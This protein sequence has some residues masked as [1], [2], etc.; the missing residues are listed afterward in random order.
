[1]RALLFLLLSACEVMPPSAC[2]PCDAV[3]NPCPDRG[4]V[5]NP[6]RGCC[7]AAPDLRPV[8]DGGSWYSDGDGAIFCGAR[9]GLCQGWACTEDR[10]C[11]P[12]LCAWADDFG[13]CVSGTCLWRM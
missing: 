2:V 13:R 7:E 1:M 8:C 9:P 3:I 5:C 11:P 6:D 10:Q 4:Q 12:T